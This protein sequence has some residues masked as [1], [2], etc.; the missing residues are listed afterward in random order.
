M[1]VVEIND[2][3]Y[4]FRIS[5]FHSFEQFRPIPTKQM[6]GWSFSS[7]SNTGQARYNDKIIVS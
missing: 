2:F 1:K 5:M 6:S 4:V 7:I 3:F